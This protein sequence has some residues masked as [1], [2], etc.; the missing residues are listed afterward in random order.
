MTTAL[1]EQQTEDVERA[2]FY[3]RRALRRLEGQYLADLTTGYRDLRGRL[4]QMLQGHI[5]LYGWQA[6]PWFIHTIRRLLDRVDEQAEE[7]ERA[8]GS[9]MSSDWDRAYRMGYFGIA[10]FLSRLVGATYPLRISR[11]DAAMLQAIRDYPYEG[12]TFYQRLGDYRFE[13]IRKLRR[14]LTLS[15]TSKE[16]SQQAAHRLR[17][18]LRIPQNQ[19]ELLARTELQHAANLGIG[20]LLAQNPNVVA[21]WQWSAL[22]DERTC[23]ICRGL[24]G[25]IF[26]VGQ[27]TPPRHARC[28]CLATPLA[29]D[30]SATAAVWGGV[31]TYAAWAAIHGILDNDDGGLRE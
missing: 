23:P 28:R 1:V 30:R 3:L 9:R 15:I 6:D 31:V 2:A 26:D 29:K 21:R 8:L 5:A 25:Q 12:A 27:P 22:L 10:W 24:H 14:E 11:L 7:M 20:A 18:A 4:L 19:A 17:S 13:F 16:S